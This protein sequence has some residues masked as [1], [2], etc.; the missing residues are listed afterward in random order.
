M[1]MQ[2]ILGS[3]N[4]AVVAG[5]NIPPLP[6]NVAARMTNHAM[7]S[8]Y[9]AVAVYSGSLTRTRPASAVTY[10]ASSTGLFAPS[11]LCLCVNSC[12][13][14]CK[15]D[16]IITVII[17]GII[18]VIITSLSVC[19]CF[20]GHFQVD[21]VTWVSRY[22]NVSILDFIGAKREGGGEW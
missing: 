15:C 22:Q 19:L 9:G 20:N 13:C 7:S 5:G 11:A 18:T 10:K 6:G 8:Y 21:L 14:I 2:T 16:F 3:R 1:I 17:I 4:N 12:H